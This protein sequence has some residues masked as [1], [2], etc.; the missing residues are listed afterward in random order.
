[1]LVFLRDLSFVSWCVITGNAYIIYCF[2]EPLAYVFGA[3]PPTSLVAQVGPQADASSYQGQTEQRLHRQ[4]GEVEQRPH[5]GPVQLHE[6]I[7]RGREEGKHSV[8]AQKAGLQA[9]RLPATASAGGET[10]FGGRDF[11][12]H[13]RNIY[14]DPTHVPGTTEKQR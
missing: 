10:L 3:G 4:P 2:S 13:S 9:D 7:L 1:M 12:F 8:S 11:H 14:S 5:V 6:G